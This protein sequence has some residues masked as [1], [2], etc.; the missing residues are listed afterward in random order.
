[1]VTSTTSSNAAYRFAAED[2]LVEAD[3]GEDEPD[4]AAGDHAEADEP[5]VAGGSE[6][7]DRGDELADDGH[8]QQR[9]RDAQHLGLDERLDLDFDPDPEEEHRDEE[10]ADRRELALDA[11]LRRAARERKPGD[12]RADDRGELRRVGELGERERE[13][14][15]QRD[16]R[17]GRLRVPVEELEEPGREPRARGPR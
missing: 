3:G 5:L 13:R 11:F 2:A 7:A 4:L 12:E 9:G 10:V 14:Q 1:M 15:R 6:H 8:D 17:A 16:Q